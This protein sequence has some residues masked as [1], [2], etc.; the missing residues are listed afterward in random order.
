MRRS[1]APLLALLLAAALPL[2]AQTAATVVTLTLATPD[3]AAVGDTVT[4]AA[5]ARNAAGAVRTDVAFTWGEVGGL[6][7]LTTTGATVRAVLEAP[8]AVAVIARGLFATATVATRPRDPV[9]RPRVVPD[10]TMPARSGRVLLVRDDLQ[11]ALDSAIGGDVVELAGRY[12]GNFVLPKRADT[13][14]VVVRG[15]GLLPDGRVPAAQ[16]LPTLLTPN[17]Q[18]AL[19]T[20][21]GASHWRVVGLAIEAAPA[22]VLAQ[23]LV[24]LG[25]LDTL[26]LAHH[27][28]LD[29]VRITGHDSLHTK[30]CVALNSGW[31]A[32]VDSRLTGCHANGQDSQAIGGWNG[33]G[34]YL[35]RN[36]LLADATEIIMFGGADPQRAGVLAAD[37]TIAGNHLTNSASMRGRW[38]VKNLLEL[39][40]AERVAIT[41]NV[42]SHI[43]P[44]G[45]KGFAFNLKA[46]NQSGTCTW[47]AVRHV[48]ITGNL[49]RDV[50][51]GVQ[52]AA[53]DNAGFPPGEYLHHVA[54]RDN[55]FE[56]V[57]AGAADVGWLL[58][59]LNQV[60][61]VWLERNVG[62][63]PM[64]VL[65]VD[66]QPMRRWTIR[67]NVFGPSQYGVKGSG[68][69]A[70]T[71]TFAK[72]LPDAVILGNAFVGVDASGYPAGNTAPALYVLPAWAT[73]LVARLAAVV[74]P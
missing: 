47:C 35:I 38:L 64:A 66:G 69:L 36:N 68:A 51:G 34:P 33:P 13:G 8:G 12:V 41:G 7:L 49:V 14:W 9:E 3:T 10:V 67:D 6:R 42:L 57:G 40:A 18:P 63:A 39:K 32:I 21:P 65:I 70:G 22:V 60:A 27:L 4:L 55:V 29:R 20:A 19:R 58:Y 28:V 54:I 59:G 1:V 45:Q 43:W 53:V 2:R 62:A 16:P 52:L 72:Y 5:T 48:T 31:A 30:Q 26:A 11:A 61:D 37:V 24:H 74:T 73:A 56:R 50:A 23:R 44:D 25:S 71:P 46:V 17:G 15:A